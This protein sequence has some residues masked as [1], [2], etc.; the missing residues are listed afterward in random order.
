MKEWYDRTKTKWQKVKEELVNEEIRY[1]KLK[2]DLVGF[3]QKERDLNEWIREAEDV[4]EQL[5]SVEEDG[6]PEEI[7][8][9]F[10]V[11]ID[12]IMLSFVNILAYRLYL[13]VKRSPF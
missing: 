11:S 2:E 5:K 10:E 4:C 7:L 8:K 13:E 9:T 12:I 1:T 3:I 6:N